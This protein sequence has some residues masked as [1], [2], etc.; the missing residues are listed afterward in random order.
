MIMDMKGR[1]YLAASVPASDSELYLPPGRDAKLLQESSLK[2]STKGGQPV[3]IQSV[4]GFVSQVEYTD[5][6]V[7]IPSR[8]NL[9]DPRLAR[10]VPPSPEEQ[11]LTDIFRR[12]GIDEV[13]R[14]LN[15]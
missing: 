3:S 14:E 4:T 7:W 13:V 8:Q 9:S 2:F 11:R 1:K 6:N 10:I 5:H 15:K 12:K